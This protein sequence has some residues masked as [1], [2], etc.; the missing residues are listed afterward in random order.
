AK[1]SSK[2]IGVVGCSVHA[3]SC[4][5]VNLAVDAEHRRHGIGTAL[6]AAATGW[7]EHAQCRSLYIEVLARFQDAMALLR[8]SG[9]TRAGVLHRHF[10]AEDVEL[11]EKTL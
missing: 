8:A 11:F 6:L 7:A 3:G 9:F 2:I 5:L 4:H 10:W 1:R